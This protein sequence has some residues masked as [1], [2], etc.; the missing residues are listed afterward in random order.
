MHYPY[1]GYPRTDLQPF[2]ASPGP[3]AHDIRTAESVTEGHPD[4]VADGIAD[5]IL[6]AHLAQDP[7]ARVAVEVLVKDDLAI[8]AGEV[9][10]QA[11]VN[12]EAVVRNAVR[13]I[14]YDDPSEPFHG[15]GLRL[16]TQLSSQ[17]GEIAAGVT[18]R[19][20]QGAGDQGLMTGYAT[21]ETAALMPLPIVLAHAVTRQ[22]A[23]DRHAG[24]VPWL[25]P[26]G[27][28]Q[29]SVRYHY[30]RPMEVTHVVVS[31]QHRADATR[32]GIEAYVRDSLLPAALGYWFTGETRLGINPA[33]SFVQGGPGADCGVT[34]RKI[35]V[36][37]YGGAARHGGGAFS[38]KDPSKVDRS[39]A[40]FC[41]WA[42][43][44]VVRKGFAEHAEVEVAYAIGVADPVALRVHTFG[45]GAPRHAERLVES[46]DWTPA[47]ILR[48]LD[49]LRPIDRGT[50]NYGHVGRP[51]L[52][53]E[54]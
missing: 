48:Q 18:G 45:T 52:P 23:A 34:G 39:A 54:M 16:V 47:A 26:D 20:V 28:A 19:A 25:R 8:V 41:R 6:D 11:T 42:A 22:L 14:G 2:L 43:R 9:T 44:Q 13:D 12:L 27:K 24:V 33:G 15:D 4:K 32:A 49:L 29:V 51:G 46:F 36:D 10:S 53:W 3:R 35:I 5:A 30:G 17:S 31:T 21:T 50:T 1:I 7:H 40:Y 38:G 37:T